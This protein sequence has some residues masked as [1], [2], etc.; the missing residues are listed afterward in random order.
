M[1]G[2][3]FEN[4]LEAHGEIQRDLWEMGVNVQSYSMQ[5]KIVEKDESYLTKELQGYSYSILEFDDKDKLPGLNLEYCNVELMDR[6]EPIKIPNPGRAWKY[7]ENIWN[8]FMHNGKF[9][10]TY[11]E[12]IRPQL[13]AIIGELINHQNTRQATINIHSNLS[14]DL[15]S[16]GG[17]S[18][19]PCSMYYQFLFRYGKLDIYYVMRSCDFITHWPFDVWLAIGLLDYV[20]MVTG[21]DIGRFFHYIGSLHVYKRDVEGKNIF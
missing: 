21:Y 7:R 8:E 16:L 5:D 18:R 10:Y 12:R 15:D 17:K 20:C 3:I 4:C 19:V 9:A 14:H 6:I 11:H 13:Q 2:R 1:A